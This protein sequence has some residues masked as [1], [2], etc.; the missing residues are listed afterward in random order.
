MRNALHL[1]VG[2]SLLLTPSYAQHVNRTQEFVPWQDSPNG[3]GTMDIIWACL[4]TVF[5]C[6]W[7]AVHLNVPAPPGTDSTVDLWLRRIKWG[8]DNSQHDYLCTEADN[9]QVGNCCIVPEIVTMLAAGQWSFARSCWREMRDILTEQDAQL[10]LESGNIT[11][12]KTVTDPFISVTNTPPS[13]PA[14]DGDEIQMIEMSRPRMQRSET[15]EE[16]R[17]RQDDERW[18][19]RHAFFANMGG[20]RLKEQGNPIPY[21]VNAKH[22]NYLVRKGYIDLPTISTLEINDRSK[23]DSLAKFLA[24]MQVGWLAIEVIARAIQKLETTVLEVTTLSFVVCTM[25]SFIAWYRKPY[26][27]QTY[28]LLEMKDGYTVN[29]IDLTFTDQKEGGRQRNLLEEYQSTHPSNQSKILDETGQLVAPY[30]KLDI[31][32]DGEPT[33]TGAFTDKYRRYW[34]SKGG[35]PNRIRNDRLPIMEHRVTFVVAVITFAYAGLHA[36]AWNIP[37]P[38][39]IEQK[40]WRIASIIMLGCCVAWF[41]MDHFQEYRLIQKSKKGIVDRDS[42]V[43]WWR[44]PASILVAILYGLSRM[45]L[46]T[47]KAER[48]GRLPPF[49]LQEFEKHGHTYT[50]RV[51]GQLVVLTR[52][53]ANVHAICKYRFKGPNMHFVFLFFSFLRPSIRSSQEHSADSRP[54]FNRSIDQDF[55]QLEVHVQ[56]LLGRLK[57]HNEGEAIDIADLLLKLSTDF[58]TQTVFGHSTDT[59]LFDMKHWSGEEQDKGSTGEFSTALG[60]ALHMLGQRGQLLNFYWLRDSPRFRRSCRT[61]RA[62]VNRYLTDALSEQ[63]WK[64]G[65]V[66]GG[67]GGAVSFL[68]SLVSKE[69][70]LSTGVMRDQLL[71]LL[72]ASR[73]T[74]ASFAS[75]VMYALVKHPRAMTKLRDAIEARLPQGT[76][77]TMTDM[78]ALPYLRHVLNEAMRIFPVVPMNG[79]T[80]R[81]D[82]VLPEGGGEDGRRPLLVPRGTTIGFNIYAMHHRRDIFGDDADEFR[83]ERWESDMSGDF[84]SAF[85]PFILGPRVCLGSEYC[86]YCPLLLSQYLQKLWANSRWKFLESMAMMTVSYLVVR[87]LQSLERLVLAEA[88]DEIARMKLTN[89]RSWP[90]EE[91]RYDMT[92]GATTFGIGITMAPRDGVWVKT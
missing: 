77:P 46:P 59:L 62:F 92:D 84:D 14:T 48:V 58:A 21:L 13:P 6:V 38:T 45:A 1:A 20:F 51:N 89:R 40:L 7:T 41:G 71:S 79:R 74:T 33:F 57:A 78:S 34:G 80:A 3:R 4:F 81:V 35:N 76:V 18:T 25:G 30:T 87:L 55:V 26:D 50:Q 73:D 17:K 9:A 52:S 11:L 42:I 70:E 66:E 22:I 2:S 10:S 83:P 44:I 28:T 90:S 12:L 60:H 8:E 5:I 53:P 29:D 82:T 68:Q 49:M 88:P 43:P 36:A 15:F 27:V 16:M 56:R 65:Q 69:A 64:K 63:A 91:T 37:L 32:D 75:W 31:I 72:L 23:S 85:A 54:H 24:I 86:S 61:C 39:D 47:L 67:R 19:L